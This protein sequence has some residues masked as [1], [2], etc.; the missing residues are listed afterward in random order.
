MLDADIIPTM[1]FIRKV[2]N[3]AVNTDGLNAPQKIELKKWACEQVIK[4]AFPDKVQFDD[5][6]DNKPA[7]LVAIEQYILASKDEKK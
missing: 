4:K 6:S 7:L 1:Q 5:V 3:D 2:L